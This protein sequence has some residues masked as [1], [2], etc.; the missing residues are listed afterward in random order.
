M[1]R[2]KKRGR[3]ALRVAKEKK[4]AIVAAGSGSEVAIGNRKVS[5]IFKLKGNWVSEGRSQTKS[6]TEKGHYRG[7]KGGLVRKSM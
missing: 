3:V 2:G 7:G 4:T 1:V 6:Q 5:P